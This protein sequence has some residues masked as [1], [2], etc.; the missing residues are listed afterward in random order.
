[1]ATNYVQPGNVITLTAPIGGVKSG[2]GFVVG[3]IFAVATTDAAE[4]ADVESALI[5]VWELP[6]A[7]VQLLQGAAAFWDVSA[8]EVVAAGGAGNAPIGAVT[9][10]AASTAATVRVRL[11]G[12]ATVVA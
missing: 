4:G 12:I 5:G 2:A 1:M 11:D 6:K 3:S 10:T 8:G 7:G 9:E